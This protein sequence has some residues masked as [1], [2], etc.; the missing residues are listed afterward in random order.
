MKKQKNT[1]VQ[2]NTK[3]IFAVQKTIPRTE[4]WL[5]TPG[6]LFYLLVSKVKTGTQA[7]KKIGFLQNHDSY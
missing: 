3:K 2:K 7:V 5:Q 4:K 1:V 6:T